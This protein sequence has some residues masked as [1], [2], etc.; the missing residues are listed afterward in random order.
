M[1]Y[2]LMMSAKKVLESN[3]MHSQKSCRVLVFNQKKEPWDIPLI[4]SLN[5]SILVKRNKK[6]L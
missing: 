5:A 1:Y 4:S 3:A 2:I 6:Y